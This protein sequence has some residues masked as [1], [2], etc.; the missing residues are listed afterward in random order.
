MN[1]RDIRG[2]AISLWA[3]DI[4]YAQIESQARS[5]NKPTWECPGCGKAML[6]CLRVCRRCYEEGKS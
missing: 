6:A 4:Q 2:D 3:R 5:E 1:I